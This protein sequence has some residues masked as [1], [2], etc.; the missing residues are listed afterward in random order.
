MRI[1]LL[2]LLLSMTL[3][4]QAAIY[5]WVDSRGA[6]HYSDTPTRDAEEVQLSDP[7]IYTPTGTSSNSNRGERQ[8]APGSGA[9]QPYASFV[10]LSP[11]RNEALH[12]NDG[13]V[14]IQ[15]AIQP[16]L[17]PGHYIQA[18]LDGR[19][20]DK[21]F[22]QNSLQL[23]NVTRGAHMIHASIHDA[24]DR[25]MA[26]SNIVQFLVHQASVIEEGKP[27]EPPPSGSGSNG[28]DAPQY[29]PG[30]VPDYSG[31]PPARPGSDA[32]DYNAPRKPIS[33]TPGQTNPAFKPNY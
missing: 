29:T 25:L 24:A 11:G 12:A 30:K 22:Y 15:F 3:C 32:S 7:T 9:S 17:Q 26:R 1:L 21:R 27:P 14:T 4:S 18:V 20:M 5:K 13:R 23:E 2:L 19:V 28:G 8:A 6:V 16:A 31:E 33:T 10:I